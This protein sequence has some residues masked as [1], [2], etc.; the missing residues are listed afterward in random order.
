MGMRR[1]RITYEG[2]LHHGMNRGYEG[3]VIFADDQDRLFFLDLLQK[4]QELTRIRILAYCLMDN[5]YHLVLQ[6]FSGKMS[7]FF[8]MLN[9]QYGAYFRKRHGG[10]GYVFQDRYK[11]ELIQDE[12]YLLIVIAYVLNNPVK[13][14]LSRSFESYPWSSGAL[15]FK[16]QADTWVDIAYVEELFGT[17]QALK[18]QVLASE[19]MEELPMVKSDM[20][21]IIGG[22]DFVSQALE[23]AERRSGYESPRN[24]RMDDRYFEPV[25]KVIQELERL[26]GVRLDLVNTRTYEGK[27]LRTELLVHLKDRAGLRYVDLMQMDIFAG[28]SAGGLGCNYRHFKR[29]RKE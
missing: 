27:R 16:K 6:N 21:L 18:K 10:R 2:A 13:K 20:G 26:H 1:A 12:A 7:E 9:G 28:M 23:K 8:K 29:K 25:E 24:R 22:E 17:P 3:R 5:H 11:S 19:A 4:V 14:G 15:Y